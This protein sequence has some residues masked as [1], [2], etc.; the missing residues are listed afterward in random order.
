MLLGAAVGP[1]HIVPAEPKPA[2]FD[3]FW[4]DTLAGARKHAGSSQRPS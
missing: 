1:T 2:D 3:A 4:A